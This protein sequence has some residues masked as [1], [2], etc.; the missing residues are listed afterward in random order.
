MTSR[1]EEYDINKA[2]NKY[3]L[4]YSTKK[5]EALRDKDQMHI[6]LIQDRVFIV[7]EKQIL[8]FHEHTSENLIWILCILSKSFNRICS[9]I[10]DF[11]F[12]NYISNICHVIITIFC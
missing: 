5:S 6:K 9:S 8:K 2:R 11:P 7:N 4:S 12:V 1:T 3:L 10:E